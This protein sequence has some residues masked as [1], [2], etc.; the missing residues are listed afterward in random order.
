MTA[1][2]WD[3]YITA[4]LFSQAIRT[5]MTC[6]VSLLN[7]KPEGKDERTFTMGAKTEKVLL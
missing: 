7:V 6:V 4:Q 3:R 5:F 2:N 1:K